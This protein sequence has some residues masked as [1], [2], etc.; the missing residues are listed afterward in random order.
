[1]SR[2][3]AAPETQA[4]GATITN[5]TEIPPD[6]LDGGDPL[7]RW[8]RETHSAFLP[9]AAQLAAV[10]LKGEDAIDRDRFLQYAFCDEDANLLVES[11]ENVRAYFQKADPYAV[12]IDDGARLNGL[13]RE[14]A[15]RHNLPTAR[16]GMGSF[17]A[18]HIN[19]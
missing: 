16:W 4:A 15:E 17:L 14:L 3:R 6:H 1:M 13:Y 11:V 12:Q 19:T 5:T 18:E 8:L 2:K 7:L 10:N 9:S